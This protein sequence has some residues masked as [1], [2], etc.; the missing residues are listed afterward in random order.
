MIGPKTSLTHL[1]SNE[2]IKGFHCRK[3][4]MY[5]ILLL[6]MPVPI[7][8]DIGKLIL[9]RQ[10]LKIGVSR[11]HRYSVNGTPGTSRISYHNIVPYDIIIWYNIVPYVL[12]IF[13]TTLSEAT[14]TTPCQKKF[15]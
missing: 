14:L 5:L 13:L 6:S 2:D 10:P 9:S 4:K 12:S 3:V 1:Y 8:Y 7:P 15:M 11:H